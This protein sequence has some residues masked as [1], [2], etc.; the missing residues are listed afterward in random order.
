MI[1]KS[2]KLL[3][4]LIIVFISLGC[5]RSSQPI[6]KTICKNYD[7]TW[8]HSDESREIKH[9]GNK[10]VFITLTSTTYMIKERDTYTY[11][12]R[13]AEVERR[14]KGVSFSY[15]YDKDAQIL[16]RTLEINVGDMDLK[17]FRNMGYMW[18][19]GNNTSLNNFTR[20]SE[21][22]GATCVAETDTLFNPEFEDFV[23]GKD[24]SISLPKDLYMARRSETDN[25]YNLYFRQETFP[26]FVI[27]V[28]KEDGVERK[29]SGLASVKDM[30]LSE[31]TKMMVDTYNL[32][33]EI[34]LDKILKNGVKDA[35]LDRLL[36]KEGISG[37]FSYLQYSQT[38]NEEEYKSFTV[39]Y[40][41]EDDAW[42]FEFYCKRKN[43]N[44]M[45]DYFEQWAKNIKI[46]PAL[47]NQ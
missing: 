36:T 19:K 32:P 22:M 2:F 9:V 12:N 29:R 3:L 35:Y 16:I 13:F 18:F 21:G 20:Q 46:T 6:K 34:N 44:I 5:N 37:K 4:S 45:R 7:E 17:E 33:V 15:S 39:F 23:V 10:I 25:G 1:K 31:V 41:F 11:I 8:T 24:T 30:T 40:Q 27:M 26:Q 47:D 28:Y 42:V 38:V 43:Y 14:V